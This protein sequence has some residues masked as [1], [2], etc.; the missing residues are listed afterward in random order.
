MLCCRP[1]RTRAPAGT[2]LPSPPG[3]SAPSRSPRACSTR[4]LPRR[5]A[6]MPHSL[7]Q[8]NTAQQRSPSGQ[9][10]L[11]LQQSCSSSAYVPKTTRRASRD[12]NPSPPRGRFQEVAATGLSRRTLDPASDIARSTS[13]TDNAEA[14]SRRHPHRRRL[15]SLSDPVPMRVAASS[16]AN[17][18]IRANPEP[19]AS[20]H[21]AAEFCPAARTITHGAWRPPQSR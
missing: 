6:P 10:R 11:S 7:P 8:G 16:L 5:S 4:R 9:T 17:R 3:T 14:F 13:E 19:L 1:G 15:N 2:R 12:A 18:R 20:R 21:H